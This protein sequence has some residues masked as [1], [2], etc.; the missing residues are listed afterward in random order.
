MN[1]RFDCPECMKSVEPKEIIIKS[2]GRMYVE[3]ECGFWAAFN[4]KDV[5]SGFH[6]RERK[7]PT[8]KCH[9]CGKTIYCKE[10]P[11]FGDCKSMGQDS[12]LCTECYMELKQENDRIA[13]MLRESRREV[14]E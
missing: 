2:F 10:C 1:I 8:T 7:S 12:C 13:E 14:H 9:H 4:Y 3:C 6:I 5:E 11:C